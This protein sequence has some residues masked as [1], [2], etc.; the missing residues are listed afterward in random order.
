MIAWLRSKTY[1]LAR[2]RAIQEG[3]DPNVAP[4]SVIRAVLTRWTSHYLAYRRL[5]R[6]RPFIMAMIQQDES[7]TTSQI[8]TGTSSAKA[9][10]VE[11]ISHLKDDKFWS[12]VIQ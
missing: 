9:K 4:L 3:I 6:L 2:L 5:I 10:A 7:A 11:A 1:V 8:I 12:A